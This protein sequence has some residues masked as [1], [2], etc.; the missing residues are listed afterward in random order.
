MFYNSSTGK[1]IVPAI[2]PQQLVR[3]HAAIMKRA[4][5]FGLIPLKWIQY[6][7]KLLMIGAKKS[8]PTRHVALTAASLPFD[9]NKFG[10]D[11]FPDVDES[12]LPADG[13]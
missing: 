6:V 12:L 1:V 3:E 2:D 5:Q 9:A 8:W 11:L 10:L 7:D 4:R 13:D